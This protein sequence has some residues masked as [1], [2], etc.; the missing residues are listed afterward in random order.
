MKRLSTITRCG[1]SLLCCEDWVRRACRAAPYWV[2]VSVP[3]PCFLFKPGTVERATNSRIESCLHKLG[4][5][6]VQ[7][8]QTRNVLAGCLH[9]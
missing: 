1:K 4:A 6:S 2:E 9:T 8:E 3:C 5:L 7:S